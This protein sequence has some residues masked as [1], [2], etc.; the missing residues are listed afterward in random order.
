MGPHTYA[1]QGG[2][3]DVESGR[4]FFQHPYYN[5]PCPTGNATCLPTSDGVPGYVQDSN[6]FN[7]SSIYPGGFTPR[8]TGDT[9][10]LFGVLGYKGTAGAFGYDVS[11]SQSSNTVD[12]GM[13]DSISPSFG[14]ESQTAFKFGDLIQKETDAN[15]DL[16]YQMEAGLASALT[17]SGGGEYRKEQYTAEVGDQ[18]SYGA[19]PYAVAHPPIH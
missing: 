19:G 3:T 7:L 13:H 4:S 14:I 11:A 6:V 12:L 18:Q 15:L 2:G 1:L 10:E 9:T 17:L 5:T 16:T 8:F